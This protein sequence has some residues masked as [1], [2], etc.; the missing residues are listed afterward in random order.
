MSFSQQQIQAIW[1]DD[2]HEARACEFDRIGDPKTANRIRACARRG[3]ARMG[4]RYCKRRLCTSCSP[5]KSWDDARKDR[6]KIEQMALPVYLTTTLPSRGLD[7][8]RPTTR[9]LRA[10]IGKLRKH[11]SIFSVTSAVGRIEP[12][13]A[14]CGVLFNVHAHVVYDAR[15][16]K[17]S[18]LQQIWDDLTEGR[19]RLLE[20][21]GAL[22]VKK[23]NVWR[24]AAYNAKTQ[25]WCPIP[26]TLTARQ[27]DALH[28]G[29]H[30]TNLTIAW[31]AVQNRGRKKRKP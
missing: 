23:K 22:R 18:P 20:P 25:D 1:F 24:V 12:K 9:E 2:P 16:V 11:Q 21:R 5:F 26:G 15:I 8:L 6:D 31:G 19:G 30:G 13:L 7:D 28:G 3:N 4:M 10:N 17:V 27:F 14:T 29:I